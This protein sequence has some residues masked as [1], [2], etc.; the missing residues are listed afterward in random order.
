MMAEKI[1]RFRVRTTIII[2]YRIKTLKQTF[3]DIAEIRGPACSG[4]GW[5]D[6]EKCIIVEKEVFDN[7]SHP[8]AKVLLN[9]LFPYYDELAYVFRRDRTTGRF[10]ETFIDI[11]FNEPT[12][13]EGFHMSNGNEEFP[14]VYSQ[15][16]DMF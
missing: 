2:D 12:G 1:P 14:S 11:R 9:K 7:W 4:L 16:I 13:Y 10:T 8:T 3:Q 5:N 15:E 6:D